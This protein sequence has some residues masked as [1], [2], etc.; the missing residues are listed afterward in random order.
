MQDHS[1]SSCSI[2]WNLS[3]SFFFFRLGV[4]PCGYHRAPK[5][6]REALPQPLLH[7]LIPSQDGLNETAAYWWASGCS[8]HFSAPTSSV[9]SHQLLLPDL[10]PSYHAN[11]YLHSS[12]QKD[13]LGS[14]PFHL[15]SSSI[16]PASLPLAFLNLINNLMEQ[17]ELC[18][19]AMGNESRQVFAQQGSN[20][21]FESNFNF[22]A[23]HLHS[24]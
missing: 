18:L 7:C 15:G 13:P 23:T 5:D 19:V 21:A 2:C 9:F 16:G 6:S 24:P 10:L 14:I 4:W 1:L 22:C 20:E 12:I 17:T 3:V 11:S 8:M